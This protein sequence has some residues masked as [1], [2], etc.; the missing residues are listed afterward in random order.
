MPVPENQTPFLWIAREL[1]YGRTGDCH[2]ADSR[3]SDMRRTD[4]TLRIPE[5]ARRVVGAVAP[6]ELPLFETT[7]QAYFA[8]GRQARAG[9]RRLTELE[10]DGQEIVPLVTTA[11]LGATAAVFE[12]L[13]S[14]IYET[15]FEEAGG[16]AWI[17]RLVRRVLRFFRRLRRRPATRSLTLP[18]SFSRE[19][20]LKVREVAVR[21]ATSLD[22]T[23]QKA[24]LIADAILGQLATSG[25]DNAGE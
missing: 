19:Q 13:A 24:E 2:Y 25:R 17:R 5:L 11:A 12:F 14:R 1:M 9:R 8:S 3:G 22:M 4:A 7:C 16:D 10:F 15:T 20:L 21:A 23:P 18:P 6:E